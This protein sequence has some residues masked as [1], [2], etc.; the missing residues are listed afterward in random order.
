MRAH[1]FCNPKRCFLGL[2]SLALFLV[3]MMTCPA[4]SQ[5]P[6][7]ALNDLTTLSGGP[8]DLQQTALIA[9]VNSPDIMMGELGV[10]SA[11]A[12]L[13]MAKGT[14]DISASLTGSATNTRAEGDGT[15]T[16][17]ILGD[18]DTRGLTLGL[19]KMFRTG[20]S[21][22]A[23]A[24]V[25]RTDYRMDATEI[26]NAAALSLSVTIPLLKGRGYVSAAAGE[27]VARL[28]SEAT[29]LNFYHTISSLLL[30]SITAYWTYKTAVENL[31]IQ[32]EGER[33]INGW[34]DV[35]ME[36]V[37]AMNF[38][39]AE[40]DVYMKDH[41]AEISRMEGYFSNKR[42]SVISATEDVSAAKSA[43]AIAIG[44]KQEQISQIG[45][46]S[47][48][49]PKNIDG[50]LKALGRQPMQDKWMNTAL[51]KRLD[52]KAAKL[53]REG[54]AVS[55][56]KAK[57]DELPSLDFTLS[58][59]RSSTDSDDSDSNH[60]FR[61]LTNNDPRGTGSGATLMFSY[62]LGNNVAKGARIS[63]RVADRI[64]VITMNNLRR[65]VRVQVGTA[66][67]ELM[68]RL[69][70]SVEAEKSVKNYKI[71]LKHFYETSRKDLLTDPNVM[72]HL[73]DLDEKLS[74]AQTSLVSS[75][76]G[77][78]VA[79]AQL[80]FQTGTILTAADMDAGELKL[81]NLSEIPG[82]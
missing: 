40:I 63:A 15:T 26:S 58:A 5:M 66:A 27:T 33:R 24:G 41:A 61:S 77:L 17:T 56:A 28:S 62:P 25:T 34:D 37:K 38:S 57:R 8:L 36:D 81:A 78:A 71:A 20:A 65:T 46:P 48:A 52:F 4:F 76:Q 21:A 80:R 59:S 30:G 73:L 60:F 55:M 7:D 82:M 6:D 9:L 53:T 49:F 69:K 75:L 39:Q 3:A 43:L 44:A 1:F 23:S 2:V 22:S 31:K 42:R 18:N 47:E 64:N 14:F 12:G 10:E 16:L 29:E 72:L 54:S 13:Q 35:I 67:S 45:A 50:A 11:R 51:A 32:E 74:A 19:S 68:R 70:E 79:I